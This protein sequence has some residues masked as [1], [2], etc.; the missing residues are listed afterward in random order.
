VT[1]YEEMVEAEKQH[2]AA[3][4]AFEKRCLTFVPWLLERICVSLGW[5]IEQFKRVKLTDPPAGS[6]PTP[7][8]YLDDRGHAFAFVIDMW[9]HWSVDFKWWVAACQDD[10]FTVSLGDRSF[11]VAEHNDDAVAEIVGHV[12]NALREACRKSNMAD[13]TSGK[14]ALPQSPLAE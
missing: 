4:D 5:P 7:D 13:V 1:F 8:G 14:L 12:Q 6:R 10:R 2:A 3:L 11:L 9:G